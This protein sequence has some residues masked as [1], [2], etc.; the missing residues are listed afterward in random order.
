M[1]RL[2]LN[3][4]YGTKAALVIGAE[5]YVQKHDHF[6]AS[7]KDQNL[8]GVHDVSEKLPLCSAGW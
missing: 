6:N 5:K 4:I 3:V 2:A 1:F 7:L 8:S